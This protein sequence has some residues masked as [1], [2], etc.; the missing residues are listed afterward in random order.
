MVSPTK[1]RTPSITASGSTG[2][3][4]H[5]NE[6]GLLFSSNPSN[7]ADEVSECPVE[8]VPDLSFLENEFHEA[9]EKTVK[10]SN[11]VPQQKGKGKSKSQHVPMLT[12]GANGVALPLVIPPAA[13]ESQPTASSSQVAP[14][15]KGRLAHI[16]WD[17]LYAQRR[18]DEGRPSMVSAFLCL[19]MLVFIC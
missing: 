17:V 9:P 3:L 2:S 13:N 5:S 12:I 16:I 10:L 4:P 11:P 7:L 18:Q 15:S 19:F 6:L 1:S 8:E 14:R